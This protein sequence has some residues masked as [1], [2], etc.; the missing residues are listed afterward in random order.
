MKQSVCHQRRTTK[1]SA[2]VRQRLD[3]EAILHHDK[4]QNFDNFATL[5]GDRYSE[6]IVR[7]NNDVR[8]VDSP[9]AF[10]HVAKV[11]KLCYEVPKKILGLQKKQ[12]TKQVV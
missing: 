5:V 3:D 1:T 7:K 11:E 4:I 6:F 12:F 10:L 8:K 2:S 9:F